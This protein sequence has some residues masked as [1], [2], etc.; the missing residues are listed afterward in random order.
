M[1]ARLTGSW[2][3]CSSRWDSLPL[4]GFQGSLPGLVTTGLSR[5]CPLD[6]P[7]GISTLGKEE[8]LISRCMFIMADCWPRNQCAGLRCRSNRQPIA[9]TRD[10]QA[11]DSQALF[12][13]HKIF[14]KQIR[15]PTDDP[16]LHSMPMIVPSRA[17]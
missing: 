4:G 13:V 1:K 17:L 15:L 12:Q 11:N 9:K 6:I 16:L 8:E 14:A 7:F 2:R 3:R 5:F 10:E